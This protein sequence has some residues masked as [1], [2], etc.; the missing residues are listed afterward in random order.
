MASEVSMRLENVDR[1]VAMARQA[2]AQSK[3]WADHVWL[4]QIA[5]LLAQRAEANQKAK[6][7]QE[8]LAEAEKAFRRAVELSPETPEAWV[9]LIRFLALTG[10]KEQAAG[11][12]CRGRQEDPRGEGPHGLGALL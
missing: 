3:D 4:G 6:E 8:Y 7:A 5:A 2:A 12:A 11:H 10:Q 1:A 9:G